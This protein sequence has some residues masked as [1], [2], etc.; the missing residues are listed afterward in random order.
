[1]IIE[2]LGLIIS[3]LGVFVGFGLKKIAKEEI[4][5]GKKNLSLLQ[6][7][8]FVLILIWFFYAVNVS[9]LYKVVIAVILAVIIYLTKNNYAILGI[10]FGLN[11]DLVLSSLIFLYGFPTGSLMKE[12]YVKIAKK[13]LIYLVLGIIALLIRN[14][15]LI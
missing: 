6:A 11:P 4:E 10:M 1:M 15:F 8:L 12:N 9:I 13:T 3:W 14:Y 7:I 2:I 5:P